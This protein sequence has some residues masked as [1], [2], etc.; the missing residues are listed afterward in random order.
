M[1]L[2]SKYW[3]AEWPPVSDT[4]G[5]FPARSQSSSYGGENNCSGT[6]TNL[7]NTSFLLHCCYHCINWCITLQI[8]NVLVLSSTT[9]LCKKWELHHL[10]FML[11]DTKL[12]VCLTPCIQSNPI[13]SRKTLPGSSAAK[14]G[15]RL[16]KTLKMTCCF[17]SAV[18]RIHR[19]H[20][21]GKSRDFLPSDEGVGSMTVYCTIHDSRN[22][23]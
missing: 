15:C 1:S 9:N 4:Y 16:R 14:H 2:P 13:H 12:H 19:K 7:N 23:L 11:Q 22:L 21:F 17:V 5:L 3:F 20:G 10:H 8:K 6:R 18:K